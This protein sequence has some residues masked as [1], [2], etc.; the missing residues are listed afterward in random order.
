MYPK[1]FWYVGAM[2][3]EV[4]RQLLART[5]LEQP[6]VFF[7]R[8]DGSVA[9]LADRCSHR[10]VSLSLGRLIGDEDQ[11]GYHGLTFAGDGS[12]TSIPGQSRVPPSACV[13]SYP[14]VE[15]DGFVWIWPGDPALANETLVPDYAEICSSGRYVGR[16]AEALLVEAPFLFNIENVLDLSHV[17]YAHPETV[18]TPEVA[19]T[20]PTVDVSEAKVQVTRNWDKASTGP[21]F[22]NLFGWDFVKNSQRIS[23]W[24]GANMLL[25]IEVEPV[26]NNDPT[27]I[28]RLR[29]PGPCTPSTSTTHFKF[30]ALY[31]DF[32]PDN[33]AL[34]VGMFEQF[35]KT[36]M[37]DKV[38]MENQQR[39]WALDGVEVIRRIEP[40]SSG[41]M[42]DIAVDHAPLAARRW[43][44]RLAMAERSAP[45]IKAPG[46]LQG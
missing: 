33:E 24:P 13:R 8:N 29:V 18:G 37:E 44:Q 21:S 12:C 27:Q 23:F 4:G 32:L 46:V 19:L 10:R 16:P 11:S 15:R 45:E 20:R 14:V 34:T 9:A 5:L 1:N 36:V 22:K 2:K 39:N 3:H 26:G 25:E 30:S 43:L 35:R 42:M 31:R 28:K 6:V 17:T 41:G 40:S 38:L 7:R